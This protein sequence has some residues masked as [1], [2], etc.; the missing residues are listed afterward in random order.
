MYCLRHCRRSRRRRPRFEQP[1]QF[2]SRPALQ[3][4]LAMGFVVILGQQF[5]RQDLRKLV[6][7]A[8]DGAA[9]L[10]L[11][12]P[13]PALANVPT[14]AVV[15]HV[16]RSA[17]NQTR[18]HE[19]VIVEQRL[20]LLLVVVL[21]LSRST[22][23]IIYY[24]I[25][26]TIQRHVGTVNILMQQAHAVHNLQAPRGR[27]QSLRHGSRCVGQHFVVVVVVVT[28]RSRSRIQIPNTGK[29]AQ[30]QQNAHDAGIFRR[31]SV[32]FGWR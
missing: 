27:Q 14:V 22:A 18:R 10:D 4:R 30:G 15:A 29:V 1:H 2:R 9:P 3:Q 32:C 26:T 12:V 25:W 5:V 6:H 23:G 31:I 19:T 24:G 7:I 21:L 16:R 17:L 11:L 20:L 8:L 28:G 13:P